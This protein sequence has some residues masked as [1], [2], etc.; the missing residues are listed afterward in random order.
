MGVSEALRCAN[1]E[2]EAIKLTLKL[3]ISPGLLLFF[4]LW[5]LFCDHNSQHL[6][7]QRFVMLHPLKPFPRISPKL[8][9]GQIFLTCNPSGV[10]AKFSKVTWIVCQW[11]LQPTEKG[12]G[13]KMFQDISS[14]LSP[15]DGIRW[16]EQ[17]SRLDGCLWGV[18]RIG[19]CRGHE[20]AEPWHFAQAAQSVLW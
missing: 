18:V 10:M 13:F 1:Q 2:N 6:I 11:R 20:K 17:L 4:H 7:L 14:I 19:E 15:R 9:K 5:L 8:R 3:A 12:S 16:Y